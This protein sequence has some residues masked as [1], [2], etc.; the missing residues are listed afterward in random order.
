MQ[1]ILDEEDELT[2]KNTEGAFKNGQRH[3]QHM[4]HN[5]MKNK[6]KTQHNICWTPL[7]ANKHNKT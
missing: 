3:W 6:A 4:V 5:P 7:Y 1:I 2:L